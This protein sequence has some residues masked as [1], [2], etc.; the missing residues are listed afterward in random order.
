MSMV[1]LV[2]ALLVLVMQ[3]VLY[4]DVATVRSASPA[5]VMLAMV[6]EG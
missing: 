2:I 3:V 4:V 6:V 1:M 5:A